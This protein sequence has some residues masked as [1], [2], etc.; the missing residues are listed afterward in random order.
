MSMNCGLADPQGF[1]DVSLDIAAPDSS[2]I[3][4]IARVPHEV[5]TKIHV[6]KAGHR[7][8]SVVESGASIWTSANGYSCDHVSV[9]RFKEKSGRSTSFVTRLVAV[10]TSDGNGARKS[11]YYEKDESSWKTVEEEKFYRSFHHEALKMSILK[12]LVLNITG[13]NKSPEFLSSSPDFPSSA[14]APNVG[15]R[16]KKVIY[17]TALGHRNNRIHVVWSRRSKD[18][19]CI[20]ASFYPKKEPKVGYLIIETKDGLQERFYAKTGT[21]GGWTVRTKEDYLNRLINAGFNESTFNNNITMDISNVDSNNFYI[22]NDPLDDCNR[23]TYI[24][25]IGFKLK[26]VM[27][28]GVSLWKAPESSDAKCRF[29]RLFIRGSPLTLL[30]LVDDPKNGRHVV[31]FVKSG[32]EWKKVGKDEYYDHIA[33]ENGLEPLRRIENPKVVMSSFTNKQGLRIATYASRVENAKGSIVLAHG[34]RSHFKIDF[35]SPNL[36]WNFEKFGFQLAPDISGIFMQ[37]NAQKT[38][39]TAMYKYLFEH[40][41]LDGMDAFEVFPVFEYRNSLVEYFNAS[42]YNVFALDHQS[43]GFSDAISKFTAY[44][45]DY[46]DYVHD[47]IQFVSIVKRGKFGDPN[48]KWDEKVAFKSHATDGK[49]FLLGNSMGGNIVFQAVQEFYKN[50]EKGAKFLD[51]LILTSGMFD[52]DYHLDT[53]AKKFKRF[54]ARC[55]SECL[56]NTLN[57]EDKLFNHGESFDLFIM[58]QDPHF[59]SCMLTLKAGKF[60]YDACDYVKNSKNLAN[61]PKTLPTLFLHTDTDFLCDV[62]GPKKMRDTYL[63]DHSDVTLAEFKGTTHFLTVPHSIVLTQKAF[64]EWL[65]KHTPSATNANTVD[66]TNNVGRM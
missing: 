57:K 23:D 55:A 20:Y 61:Y 30:L 26:E 27:D 8:S 37:G 40:A 16:I 32:G 34:I 7:I 52:L 21:F 28:G 62:K 51:G 25:S 54:M 64:K 58:Y 2:S 13:E 36:E 44:V 12:S 47:V 29:V 63:K 66:K 15:Y 31:Y 22:K 35:C 3:D 6:A 17:K 49:V 59:Y 48:E 56:L 14:Y 19:H 1:K 11:F 42:G 41:R 43:H 65:S 4:V 53:T 50:A 46:K 9:V 18:E 60:L 5:N 10:Y 39:Y 45:K 24:P 33:K 38:N